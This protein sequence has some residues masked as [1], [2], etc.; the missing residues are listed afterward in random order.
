MFRCQL[1]PTQPIALFW[2]VT[3][4]KLLRKRLAEQLAIVFFSVTCII[5]Y[6]RKSLNNL[7][8][9]S[10]YHLNDSYFWL[11]CVY[12]IENL[13]QPCR[14]NRICCQYQV[15]NLTAEKISRK[16]LTDGHQ[17]V[18]RFFSIRY[19]NKNMNK[20]AVTCGCARV[21]FGFS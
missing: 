10:V 16:W 21:N 18:P 13:L 2:N 15:D 11:N 17:R 8:R 6:N 20:L 19:L 5:T 9:F 3:I 1:L 7:H 12:L 14:A 4:L